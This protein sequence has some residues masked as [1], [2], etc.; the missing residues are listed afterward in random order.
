[1]KD[2]EIEIKE[3]FETIYE[4]EPNVGDWVIAQHYYNETLITGEVSALKHTQ[5]NR[6]FHPDADFEFVVWGNFA[7]KIAGI[8]CW[9]Q[10]DDWEIISVMK[11]FDDKKLK[12]RNSKREEE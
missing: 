1:M 7:I 2:Y 9:L 6:G 5:P 8:N 12:K 4:E 11:E 3:M 10:S